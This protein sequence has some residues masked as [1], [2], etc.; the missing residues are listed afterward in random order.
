MLWLQFL[1]KTISI[2]YNTIQYNTTNA[3]N[4]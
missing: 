2:E 1:I 3:H 4:Y